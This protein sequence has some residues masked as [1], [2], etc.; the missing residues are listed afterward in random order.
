MVSMA[1]VWVGIGAPV[2]DVVVEGPFSFCHIRFLS[3][4]QH[5]VL[6]KPV[7]MKVY[8]GGDDGFK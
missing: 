7:E 6:E 2:Q 3:V 8:R 5:E 1:Q 4:I